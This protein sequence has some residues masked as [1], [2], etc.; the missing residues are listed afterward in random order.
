MTG[1]NLAE[2]T[3]GHGEIELKLLVTQKTK[4]PEVQIRLPS[5]APGHQRRR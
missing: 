5:S 1:Y 2:R 4:T 3:L